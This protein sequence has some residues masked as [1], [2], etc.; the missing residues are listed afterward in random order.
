MMQYLSLKPAQQAL[1]GHSGFAR[2]SIPVLLSPRQGA[3][4]LPTIPNLNLGAGF[5]RTRADGLAGEGDGTYLSLFGS[6]SMVSGLSGTAW[7]FSQIARWNSFVGAGAQP[8]LQAW[9]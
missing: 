6:N 5:G 1:T 3:I 2:Y 9:R 8:S 7:T 4:G